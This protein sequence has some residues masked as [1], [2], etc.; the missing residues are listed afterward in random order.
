MEE[1]GQKTRKTRHIHTDLTSEQR[2]SVPYLGIRSIRLSSM[3]PVVRTYNYKLARTTF[4]I[5]IH[6]HKQSKWAA[7]RQ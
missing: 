6:I 1:A 7:G 5:Y 2:I 3:G 4:A